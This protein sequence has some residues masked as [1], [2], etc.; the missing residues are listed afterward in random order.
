MITSKGIKHFGINL[1][2]EVKGVY[3]ENYKVLLKNIKDNTNKWKDI[4]CSWIG[5]LNI[6]KMSIRTQSNLQIQCNS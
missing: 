3:T 2:E 5:I 6:V 4:P 1:T